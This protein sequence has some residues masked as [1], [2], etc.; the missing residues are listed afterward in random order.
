MINSDFLICLWAAVGAVWAAPAAFR[1]ALRPFLGVRTPGIL[2]SFGRHLG[3]SGLLLGTLLR[4][5]DQLL[6]ASLL[7]NL[8]G[9]KTSVLGRWG[10]ARPTNGVGGLMGAK[11]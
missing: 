10:Y 6:H 7:N 4:L 2:G 9:R 11:G 1:A 3:L 5:P 8:S